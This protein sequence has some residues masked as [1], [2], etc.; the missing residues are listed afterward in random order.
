[1]FSIRSTSAISFV[2]FVLVTIIG[3]LLPTVV[4]GAPLPNATAVDRA[5]DLDEKIRLQDQINSEL[6][7]QRR[8]SQAVE[9]IDVPKTP[10]P[11]I[12]QGSRFFI[13]R[14]D[15]DA[16]AFADYA[17]DPADVLARYEGRELGAEEI[18][19]VIRDLSN[20]YAAQGY[21]TTSFSVIPA[22]LK[23]GV[24]KLQVN[25]GLVEG[26]RINGRPPATLKE[27]MMVSQ[28]MPGIVGQP[29][30]I[31]DIDQAIENLNNGAKLAKVEVMPSTTLGYSLLNINTASNPQPSTSL[32][33]DNSGLN[34]PSNGRYRYTLSTA[35]SDLLLGNDTLSFNGSGR[36]FKDDEHN[37][38]YS[39]GV[40]YSVPLGYSLISLRYNDSYNSS[41]LSGIYGDYQSKGDSQTYALNL[42]RVMWRDAQSKFTVY[43]ELERKESANYL[44]GS[45]V[46]ANSKRY[47]SFT[48]G[49]RNVAPLWGGVLYSDIG[50]STGLSGQ[51]GAYGAFDGEGKPVNYKKITFNEAWSYRFQIQERD[52]EYA[53]RIGGQVAQYSALSS[54]KQGLGDEYTVRGFKGP[55]LWGDRAVFVSN[56]LNVPIRLASSTFVPFLGLDAGYVN[57]IDE[58][59]GYAEDASIAG[60][61]AGLNYS[62]AHFRAGITLARPLLTPD[63]IKHSTDP[64]IA[65]INIGFSI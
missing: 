6:E 39:A 23:Q 49:L 30:N 64:Y 11:V 5:E 18:F 13:E 56:T 21:S 43:S 26:W 36:R 4:V 2:L 35:I 62:D 34:S 32:G 31:R 33:M 29:L 16:G 44:D 25:W 65:Y 61:A 27:R 12:Q 57:E 20:L 42:S 48:L 3:L 37:S 15:I 38:E 52:L 19:S 24:L 28:A 10:L 45:Y 59:P 40:S 60:V 14:I 53:V 46:Q 8:R 63:F 9:V 7:E 58:S 41:L 47:D 50:L 55:A 17:L 1:M 51:G 22:S 54:F